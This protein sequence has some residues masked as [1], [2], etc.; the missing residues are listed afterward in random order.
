[1]PITFL[2]S[3]INFNDGTSQT[4][5]SPTFSELPVVR[6]Y[7][8]PAT[9]TKPDRLK[10][11]KVIV[12]GAGGSGDRAIPSWGYGGAGGGAGGTAIKWL[13]APQLPSSVSVTVGVG[14]GI[15]NV[16]LLPYP[17]TSD[18]G[19]SSFGTFSTAFGGINGMSGANGGIA[20]GGD[21]NITGGDGHGGSSGANTAFGSGGVGGSSFLGFGGSPPVTYGPGSADGFGGKYGG[22]GGGGNRT[23]NSFWGYGANG[24]VII[25]EFY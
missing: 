16:N 24:V 4:T 14:G 7:E 8:S 25:E 22:G 21:V 6:I 3:S 17:S 1:M 19:T 13:Q 18:G 15:A 20:V 12:V 2:G 9:W 11:V 10:G 5:R 23:Y